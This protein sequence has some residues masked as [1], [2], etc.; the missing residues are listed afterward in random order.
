MT[1]TIKPNVPS[2]WRRAKVSAESS[3]ERRKAGAPWVR[4]V[5][6]KLLSPE[7]D[8]RIEPRI[9][10]VDHEV[11]DDEDRHR[12]HHQ[13]LG[14]RVVLVLHRQHEQPADAVQVEDLLG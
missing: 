2:G 3:H 7:P 11:G 12:Q 4:T 13:R 14:E 5:I 8:P 1:T 10:N 6:A 9:E